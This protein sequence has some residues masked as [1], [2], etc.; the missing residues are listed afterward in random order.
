MHMIRLLCAAIALFSMAGCVSVNQIPMTPEAANG[1]K[2]KEVVT[3]TRKKPGFAAMTAGKAM[4]AMVGALAMISAGN[5]IVAKNDIQD[6]AGYISGKLGAALSAK[7]GTRVSTKTVEITDEDVQAISKSNPGVDLILDVR[8]I[9]WSFAYFPTTWNKYHVLYSARLRLI[10]V[11]GARVVSEGF[12][13][14][15]PEETPNSPTYEELLANNAQRLKKE[16]K[17][18]AD[19]CVDDFKAEVLK[20]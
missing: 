17:D 16:L 11:K 19:Y 8:T 9:N 12:C 15:V 1:I 13:S 6:P 2:D 18:D 10:D 5:E 20:L 7:Y 14:R 4:F 3:G